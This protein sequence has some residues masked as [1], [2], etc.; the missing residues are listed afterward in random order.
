MASSNDV[1]VDDSFFA[2]ILTPG[3]SLNPTFLAILDSAF[4]SL[5]L[6]LLGLAF[7][8]QSPHMLALMVIELC[9][10]ASVKWYVNELK[11][12][13]VAVQGQGEGA[14]SKKDS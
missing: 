4:V 1:A 5:F 8:T 7:V 13:P 6:V 9:L 3:S 10:W 14:E 2:N 12:M 11:K